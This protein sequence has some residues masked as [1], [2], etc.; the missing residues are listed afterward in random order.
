MF[1]RKNKHKVRYRDLIWIN[2]DTKYRKL[3]SL[4]DNGKAALIVSSFENTLKNLQSLNQ[5]FKKMESMSDF[6]KSRGPWLVNTKLILEATSFQQ[7]ITDEVQIIFTEH[8]PMPEKDSEILSKTAAAIPNAEI[9]FYI[10]LDDPLMRLFNS[11]K[12]GDMMK[13]MG[14]DENEAIE[15]RMISS[16]IFNAQKKITKKISFEQHYDDEEAWYRMNY[17][18]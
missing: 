17:R 6:D 3:L 2:T 9:V 5:E 14:M 7:A 12:I 13:N 16:A 4:P 1:G 18:G 11:G 15:H 10:S 8:Y